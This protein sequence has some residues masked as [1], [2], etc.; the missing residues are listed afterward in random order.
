[1]QTNK[2]TTLNGTAELTAKEVRLI[3]PR[4]RLALET[5]EREGVSLRKALKR[6]REAQAHLAVI[7]GLLSD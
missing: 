7:V 6:N 5:L 2:N 3:G 4:A 1:M